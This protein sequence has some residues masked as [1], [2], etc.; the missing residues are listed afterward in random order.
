MARALKKG[1]AP[2]A[3]ATRNKAPASSLAAPKRA[4][5]AAIK[6]DRF[7][8]HPGVEK[9]QKW[10]AELKP[11]TGRTL[12]EWV[13]LCRK[14]GPGDEKSCRAWLKEKHGLGTNTSAWMAEKA[15][16]APGTPSEDSPDAYLAAA[17]VYTRDLYAGPKAALKPIHDE[18]VRAARALGADVKV[19]PC[20]TMIPLYRA[21]VFAQIRP[22]TRARVDL[23]LCL[24]P[25]IKRG[26][27]LPA[28]LIDTGGFA[29]KDRITHRIELTGPAM[30]DAEARRWLKRAY[31]LEA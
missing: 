23:G 14:Q 31:E 27:A 10:I 4:R 19:C 12:D 26:T 29:K 22:A 7:D 24:T 2:R 30:F 16:A 1:A 17:A 20:K 13:T 8:V 15:H 6:A 9:V 11:R 3:R 5:P 21:H 18:I 25:L 28:R